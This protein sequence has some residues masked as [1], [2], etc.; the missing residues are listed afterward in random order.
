M[1]MQPGMYEL[2]KNIIADV[3]AL[4]YRV[5][6][7]KPPM[8]VSMQEAQRLNQIAEKIM[9]SLEAARLGPIA[10]T[11]PSFTFGFYRM[12]ADGVKE[13]SLKNPTAYGKDREPALRVL[14]WLDEIGHAYPDRRD[15]Y[16]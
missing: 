4:I 8:A 13:I 1:L 6:R 11:K 2:P 9:P 15:T 10:L 5:N 12:L 7:L 16:S 3:D 14:C